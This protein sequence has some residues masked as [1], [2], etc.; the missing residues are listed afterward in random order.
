MACT[1]LDLDT[2]RGNLALHPPADEGVADLPAHQRRGH[3]LGA[4]VEGS[5]Y[6]MAE[7]EESDDF[8]FRRNGRTRRRVV[9]GAVL[10][11]L[12]SANDSQSERDIG[13]LHRGVRAADGDAV[14]R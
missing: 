4:P 14:F 10:R 13:K 3:D 7:S 12:L 8:P 2:S 6:A 5:L 11:A 1:F 9:H